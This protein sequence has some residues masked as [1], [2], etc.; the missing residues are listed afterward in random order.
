MLLMVKKGSTE[1]IFHAVHRYAKVNDK[2][3][4]NYDKNKESSY[5]HYLDASNLYGWVMSQWMPLDGFKWKNNISKLIENVMKSNNEDSDKGYIPEVDVKYPKYLHDLDS[6]LPFLSE[7]TPNY[8]A[9]KWFSENLLAIE[10]K[11]IKE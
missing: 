7:R 8:H 10:M 2:Y 3:M 6:D 4:K 11:G 1:G 5:I 9:T